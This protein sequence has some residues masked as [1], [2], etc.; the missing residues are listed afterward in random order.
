M[1]KN[2]QEVEEYKQKITA[3]S[4]EKP[5]PFDFIKNNWD[6]DDI[7]ILNYI[8]N[9]KRVGK[10][11]ANYKCRNTEKCSGPVSFLTRLREDAKSNEDYEVSVPHVFT[12]LNL[13][14]I[15]GCFPIPE[16][17]VL[18]KQLI[19]N[20]KQI[21]RTHPEVYTVKLQQLYEKEQALI[22]SRT[23]IST[24]D[25]VD[26]AWRLKDEKA[27][28]GK[29]LA[30]DIISVIIRDPM[31]QNGLERF[32]VY[33][34]K[35]ENRLIV[36]VSPRGLKILAHSKHW[37]SDGTFHTASKYFAQMYV[38]HAGFEDLSQSQRTDPNEIGVERC[39]PVVWALMK[40]R[41]VKDY[42]KL[43]NVL[44]QQSKEQ[45]VQLAPTQI[46]TDFEKSAMKSFGVNIFSKKI[47]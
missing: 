43:N 44:I 32:C 46:M 17:E 31:T 11:A 40:R 4:L 6:N 8:Y 5:P 45:G 27:K 12:H 10:R 37:H 20:C 2:L 26:V 30:K 29:P 36:F 13:K 28:H 16:K 42:N 22:K 24:K 41:R 15:D 1:E 38:I 39:L 25:Y 34:N 47:T 33:D 7:I 3:F 35:T 14:H 19:T 23:G 9:Q 18:G 21:L